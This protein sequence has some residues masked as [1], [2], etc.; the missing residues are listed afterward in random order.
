MKPLSVTLT[1]LAC[2]ALPGGALAVDACALIATQEAATIA[3]APLPENYRMGARPGATA[4]QAQASVCGWFPQHYLYGVEEDPPESGVL[5][6]L[7]NM[8]SPAEARALF[9][10]TNT[11]AGKLNTPGG[12]GAV[13][14]VTG[15]GDTAN[16]V[17]QPLNGKYVLTLKFLKGATIAYVQVWTRDASAGEALIKA[18]KQMASKL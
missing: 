12:P 11:M 13:V 10:R 7:R 17:R 2:L 4:A 16:L 3:G 14:P 9:E 5:L 8:Q 18:A 15:I 6:T 1:L